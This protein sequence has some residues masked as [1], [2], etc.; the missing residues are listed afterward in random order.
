LPSTGPDCAINND[1]LANAIGDPTKITY[2][3]PI[4]QEKSDSQKGIAHKE[5]SATRA[6]G[7]EASIKALGW[8]QHFLFYFEY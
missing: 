4:V 1:H 2:S 8:G 3:T 7:E 5:K 6:H